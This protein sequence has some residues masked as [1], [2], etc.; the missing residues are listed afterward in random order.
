[1][2]SSVL[3]PGLRLEYFHQ[4]DWEEEWIENAEMLVHDKYIACYEGKAPHTQISLHTAGDAIQS[5]AAMAQD[6]KLS[7]IRF[8][9][10]VALLYATTNPLNI[11]S[12]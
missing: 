3:H 5:I 4:H 11:V 6:Q 8:P 12:H 7:E 1:M 2:L 9:E 10:R